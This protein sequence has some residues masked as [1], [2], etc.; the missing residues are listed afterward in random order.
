MK[1]RDADQEA[2]RAVAS[3]VASRRPRNLKLQR[4]FQLSKICQDKEEPHPFVA[5]CGRRS[6]GLKRRKRRVDNVHASGFGSGR[7]SAGLGRIAEV[8]G[9]SQCL[10]GRESGSSPTSG[11]AS[12][13][14]RGVF[15]LMCGH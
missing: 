9:S 4:F 7:T 10:Q 12:P 11:T 5:G 6:E 2:G 14:V 15:A 3:F 13:L 1:I 8:F